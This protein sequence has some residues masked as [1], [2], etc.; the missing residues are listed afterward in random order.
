MKYR[1]RNSADRLR[2]YQIL[3]VQL[4]LVSNDPKP[5]ALV[6]NQSRDLEVD[7]PWEQWQTA[8]PTREPKQFWYGRLNGTVLELDRP[9]PWQGW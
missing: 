7:V 2:G 5:A 3:K 1:R 4:P 9:A 8:L 6:Y